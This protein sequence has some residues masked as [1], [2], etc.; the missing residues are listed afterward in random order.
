MLLMLGHVHVR[1]CILLTILCCSIGIASLLHGL[2]VL[3]MFVLLLLLVVARLSI[4]SRL[5]WVRL[6]LWVTMPLLLL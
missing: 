6:L 2:I 4:L 1:P 5:I 3:L